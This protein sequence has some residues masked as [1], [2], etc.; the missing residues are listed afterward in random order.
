MTEPDRTPGVSAESWLFAWASAA[1]LIALVL[2]ALAIPSEGTPEVSLRSTDIQFG[3]AIFD[4]EG[5]ISCHSRMVRTGDRGMGSP[6]TR[7]MGSN[8]GS[9]RIGPDLQNL[10]RRYPAS[11][12]EKRLTEPETLQPGTVMPSYAHLGG[13]KRAALVSYLEQSV[14]IT[15]GW[16]E[17]REL[18]MIEPAIPDELLVSL[19]GYLDS[20]TGMFDTPTTDTRE[21]LI[22]ASGL[23]NSRCAACHGME[24]RGDGPVS[25]LGGRSGFPGD[26]STALVPPAD[27]TGGEF[28]NYSELM[29]YWRISEGVPGTEMPAWG[30]TLSRDAIWYL[31]GYV[32]S[33]AAGDER[34]LGGGS[35]LPPGWTLGDL[36]EKWDLVYGDKVPSPSGHTIVAHPREGSGVPAD[37][38]SE[39]EGAGGN[40]DENSPD[41]EESAED[42]TA[43]E[44]SP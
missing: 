12:L 14:T 15:G 22:T 36:L 18:N 37:G 3:E 29:F 39:E 23:Y 24:G 20:D 8:P 1:F 27:F 11:L 4:G 2:A 17:V 6:A 28:E 44:E 32:R 30:G 33:L 26:G 9:S 34:S 7:V 43:G 5:C 13:G 35:P 21:F 10:D 40:E 25:W 16:A 38:A 42:L 19:Q 31:V 41:A